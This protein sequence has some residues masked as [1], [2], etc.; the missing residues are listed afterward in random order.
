MG[1]SHVTWPGTINCCQ[2]QMAWFLSCS[3]R[4]KKPLHYHQQQHTQQLLLIVI[5]S[6]SA[7]I[8]TPVHYLPQSANYLESLRDQSWLYS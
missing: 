4:A 3:M 7:I 1:S 5:S 2:P 8:E 6:D